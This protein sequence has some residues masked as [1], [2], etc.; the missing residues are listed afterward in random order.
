MECCLTSFPSLP[1]IGF[2]LL[3]SFGP[4]AF[5]KVTDL[6]KSEIDAAFKKPVSP[7]RSQCHLEV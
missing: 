4:W 5:R 7:L 2:L 1:R 6:V 3:I